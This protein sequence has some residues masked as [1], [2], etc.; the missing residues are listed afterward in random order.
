M[1]GGT[2]THTHTHTHTGAGRDAENRCGVV[3]V[4][5][6]AL[7]GGQAPQYNITGTH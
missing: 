3:E 7:C 2:R 4:A 1:C 6:V 5:A